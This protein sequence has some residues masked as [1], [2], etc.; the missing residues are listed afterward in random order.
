MSRATS[1]APTNG[2]HGALED[3]RDI[4]VRA[5]TAADDRARDEFVRAHPRGTFFHQSG[6]RRAVERV[7]GHRPCDLVAHQGGELAGVL[8]LMRAPSLWGADSL[9]SMPYAVYG[10]ALGTSPAVEAALYATA[11]RLAGEAR[12]GRLEVRTLEEPGLGEG[13][14]SFDLHATFVQELPADPAAVLAGMPKKAR[15]EARKAREHGLELSEGIW[16][17][18]DLYRLFHQ[19]KKSLGSPGLPLAWFLCLRREFE[20]QVTVHLVHRGREPLAA[21]M[22]FLHGDSVLAYYSGTAEGADRQFS[23][24]NF[25]YMALREW[26]VVNGF[27]RFDFGR[28]RKGSGAYSFKEHQGFEARD[29]SYRIALVR[30]RRLPSFHPSNPKTRLPRAIWSQ[31]PVSVTMRAS[32][33]LARYLPS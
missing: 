26:S 25:M 33:A 15:A 17:L 20:K 8:P 4:E 31:L 16:Y 5:G 32:D 21:V 28:S 30:D 22:S 27:K 14:L 9:I 11:R 1:P 23:A 19:N 13:W 10:G 24:S 12:V 29:L 18:P 6:W 2:A 7:F 3:A